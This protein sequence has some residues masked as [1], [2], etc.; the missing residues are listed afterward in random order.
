MNPATFTSD[1]KLF[2]KLLTVATVKNGQRKGILQQLLTVYRGGCLAE[3]G[4]EWAAGRAAELEMLC[5]QALELLQFQLS[6]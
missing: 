4:Y 6:A 3:N 1:L 2:E 5:L